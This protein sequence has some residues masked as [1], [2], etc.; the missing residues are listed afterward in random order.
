MKKY[1][2]FTAAIALLLLLLGAVWW[3][4]QARRATTPASAAPRA[5]RIT[6]HTTPSATPSAP[7]TA[8]ADDDRGTSPAIN[9]PPATSAA[10]SIEVLLSDASLHDQTIL[11]GLARITLDAARPQAER[12]EALSHLLNLSA[13]EPASALLPLV[14]DRRLPKNL[15][16]QILDDSLNAPLAWQADVHLAA[17]TH[18]RDAETKTKAREHLTFLLDAD[19][20]DNLAAWTQAVA[21]ARATWTL[22]S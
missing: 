13:D 16:N 14:A 1:S 4:Q 22:D 8:S 11:A 15:C 7:V 21:D 5:E 2:L 6:R 18:R 19:H 3:L 12:S 9:A 20:G 17:L 10:P